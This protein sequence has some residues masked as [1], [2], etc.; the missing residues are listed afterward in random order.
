MRAREKEPGG[1]A[2]RQ[3]RQ[4]RLVPG[5]NRGGGGAGP[6]FAARSGAGCTG[7]GQDAGALHQA[8]GLVPGALLE[9]G[10]G[11]D[12]GGAAVLGQDHLRQRDRGTGVMLGGEARAWP[13]LEGRR[14]GGRE[15]DR[16]SI[17]LPAQGGRRTP[18]P[19][20]CV[21]KERSPAEVGASFA[22]GPRTS[23]PF[24]PS[25]QRMTAARSPPCSWKEGRE[26]PRMP[27]GEEPLESS[28]LRLPALLHAT[29]PLG[30]VLGGGGIKTFVLAPKTA[31]VHVGIG[32]S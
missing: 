23:R 32:V 11:A 28:P 13:G 6:G 8:A 20:S 15:G 25:A 9:G 2:R 3:Q 18:L 4:G 21:W 5:D 31:P 17:F 26:R 22:F 16:A 1:R 7:R 27:C 14:E 29:C 19:R 24:L 10:D 30:D 12:P